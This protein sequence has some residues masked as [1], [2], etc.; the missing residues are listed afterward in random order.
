MLCKISSKNQITLPKEVLSSF[1]G[2]EYFDAHVEGGRIILDPMIVRPVES[3]RLAAIRDRMEAN[4]LDESMVEDL[5][6]EAK[7]EY[8]T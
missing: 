2:H 4:G 8:R 3:S 6:A 7:R 5:V 1:S